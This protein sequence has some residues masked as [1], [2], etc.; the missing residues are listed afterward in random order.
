MGSD[1][2][3]LVVGI[4]GTIALA[5]SCK[6]GTPDA[7][8]TDEGPT[9]VAAAPAAATPPP[10]IADAPPV[11]AADDA[12]TPKMEAPK[13]EAPKAE[14]PKTEAP[15]AEA[16]KAGAPKAE[17]PPQPPASTK[18]DAYT[19]VAVP[20]PDKKT[21]RLWKAKCAS[22]HG[23]DGK[24]DTD[25]GK[26]MKVADMTSA[27]WQTARTNAALAKAINEGV[28]QEVGGVKKEM[29]PFQSDLS[30]EQVDA[31]VKLIRW[32]GAPR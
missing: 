1:R 10:A 30:P 9:V 21:E 32:F 7:A 24:A 3:I 31:L 4:A 5:A 19:V 20:A 22:C 12:G 17:V 26:Q 15:K 13:A 28:N 16:P 6:E 25:K 23:A 2:W 11:M 27:A 8:K 29:D 18:G 14:A